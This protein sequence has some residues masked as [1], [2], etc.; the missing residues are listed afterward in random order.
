[1]K[2]KLLSKL[3]KK[4]MDYG[5]FSRYSATADP[6][7]YSKTGGGYKSGRTGNTA[8]IICAGDLMCEPAMSKAVCFNG[9]F[10]FEV[11]FSQIRNV[12]AESDFAIANLETMVYSKA[13]Y[14]V[15][16]H[17]IDGRYHCNAPEEYLDALRYA[18]FD[19]LVMANNHSADTGPEGLLETIQQVDKRGFMHTGAFRDRTEKR[20]ILADINGIRV[21]V[22]S[23]T[24]HINKDIDKI[25]FI[26]NTGTIMINRYSKEKLYKDIAD[27]KK[28]GA[29]FCICYIHFLCKEYSNDVTK[30]QQIIA[31]EIADA[32]VDC[33]M[34]SHAH[35][36]QRYDRIIIPNRVV[37]VVYGLGNFISSDNTGMI[38]HR[39]VIYHLELGRDDNGLVRI[40]KEGCVPC[41]T[42]EGIQR[43]S[44]IVFPTPVSWRG[45]KENEFLSSVENKIITEIGDKLPVLGCDWRNEEEYSFEKLRTLTLRKICNI[46]DVDVPDKFKAIQE[47]P[48]KYINAKDKW[49]TKGS[50]YFSRYYGQIEDEWAREAFKR[51]A[52]VL[53]TS[54][55]IQ[56]YDGEDLPCIIV[57]KPA[58]CFYKVNAWIKSLYNVKTV[59]ITG[60]VGKTTTKDMVSAVLGTQY[61]LL[62]SPGNSNTYAGIS[63]TIQR[64][65]PEHEMYVQEVCA[66]SPGWV[67]GSSSMLN[68]DACVVTN[69]GYPHIDLYGSIE[70]ILK[71]KMTI[72]KNMK[73]EGVAFLNYDDE[74]IRNYP[75][76]CKVVS[77]SVK[78]QDADY[79]ADN[80][81]NKNG[82]LQF[83][84]VHGNKHDHLAI[85]MYGEHNVINGLVAFAVGEY[86]G[87][88]KENIVKALNEYRSEGIRQSVYNIGGYHLYMDC[89]N[90]APNSIIGSVRTLG[91]LKSG[92][93]SRRIVLFGDIP[94]L[95]DEAP[96]VHEQVAE[97]LKEEPVDQYIFYG[98]NAKYAAEV[99]E[100]YGKSVLHTEN[101]DELIKMLRANVK[102]NDIMLV[103][104][105][106]P[107]KITRAVDKCFGTSFH[108]TDP[109]VLLENTFKIQNK[110]IDF[111]AYNVDGQIEIRSASNGLAEVVIPT[112]IESSPVVRI[113]KEAFK[114][115]SMEKIALPE[116]IYNVGQGA[117]SRCDNLVSIEMSRSIRVVE[118][119]A[120]AMCVSLKEI[121]F[122]K[123]LIHLGAHAFF[124]CK[125]LEKIHI[126]S[127][128]GEIGEEC[129]EGCSEKLALVGNKGSFAEEYARKA[130]ISFFAIE[131][132]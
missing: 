67:E 5:E 49:M 22:L 12:L 3:V 115:H 16:K 23:Y 29:E 6:I 65:R 18:G 72:V 100:Q 35:A 25:Y 44:F 90:S 75:V 74:L 13:P 31:K 53:F 131:D 91:N 83:D 77:Y 27:A 120:F 127:T 14:A 59:D 111:S 99:L 28:D 70:N 119:D 104:A 66:F 4:N 43:S 64:L 30:H 69:I 36:I 129:F 102:L 87:I 89:Y 10:L 101:E 116:T 81:V 126:P 38:T 95:G 94:R 37:P 118:D 85:N 79:Y 98:P 58:Q 52:K 50:V 124:N 15:D 82:I 92:K 61:N 17:R 45:G 103:K 125:S 93:N 108:L 62:K 54:K 48:V 39:S 33:I 84:V 41:R 9:K 7:R 63:D 21:A 34:G 11:C 8:K 76:N 40:I 123:G 42:V 132:E 26:G 68:A 73:P 2:P 80:I 46:I 97:E 24:E 122:P 110:E 112:Y 106:H 114:D 113:G 128:V 130:N 107:M 71:D 57:S 105:G 1:M 19:A 78:N 20:Y 86:F 96:K 88:S 121:R 109:D 60:S 51:G 56:T 47:E 32:G 117:F 55:Q